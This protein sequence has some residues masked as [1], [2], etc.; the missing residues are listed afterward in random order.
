MTAVDLFLRYEFLQ[1]ALVAA[2]VMGVLAGALGV[3]LVLREMAMFGHGFAH[4]SYAGVALGVYAGV[5]PL[6]VALA[7]TVAGA[8]AIEHLRS[9]DLLGGDTALAMVVSVAFAIGVVV[10]SLAGGFTTDLHS[11]LFGSLFA[12]STRDLS[13]MIPLAGVLLG[14]FALLYKEIFYLAFDETGARLS[15]LPVAWLNG[16]MMALTAATIVL[17]S[18]IV[19]L[20]LVAA[21]LVIPAATALQVS[22]RF[23]TAILGAMAAGLVSAV[24]GLAAAVQFDVASG[25]AIV[26]T[27]AA[28][29]GL[30]SIAQR[31]RHSQAT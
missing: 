18:R 27:A 21:L 4:I 1:L 12:V 8:L 30:V 9:Q 6:G 29:F 19:G 17:A 25:G 5:F 2:C 10:V 22:K 14:L 13:L 24:V 31:A 20:L 11:Y 7:V 23:R 15:G 26:L 28:L 3:P 16:S